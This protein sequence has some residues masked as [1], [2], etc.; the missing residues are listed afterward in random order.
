MMGSDLPESSAMQQVRQG[1][2]R[3]QCRGCHGVDATTYVVGVASHRHPEPQQG[4][5]NLDTLDDLE[6][7]LAV[8]EP[9]ERKPH[10]TKTRA[11]LLAD[12][13]G[14]VTGDRV[15]PDRGGD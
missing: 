15:L 10:D 7:G 6:R 8:P 2:T 1:A 5:S 12:E 4:L 13:L 3:C 14:L 9:I 11:R